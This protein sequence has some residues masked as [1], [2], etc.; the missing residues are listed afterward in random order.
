VTKRYRIIK[1]ITKKENEEALEEIIRYSII[2][3]KELNIEVMDGETE[4]QFASR[5]LL[6]NDIDILKNIKDYYRYK[7][8]NEKVSR[9]NLK[10]AVFINEE[11]YKKVKKARKQK[12]IKKLKVIRCLK[13]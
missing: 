3:L 8:N 10:E 1:K 6:E 7:Y 11:I 5:V 13:R 9:S 12:I 4:M 2:L